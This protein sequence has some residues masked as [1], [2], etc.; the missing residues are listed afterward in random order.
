MILPPSFVG[1]K[2]FNTRNFLKDSRVHLRTDSV[3]WDKTIL[4]D[5]RETH[6][7]LIPNTFRYPKP[8]ETQKGSSTKWFGTVRQNNFDGESWKPPPLLSLTIFDNRNFLKHRRAP[9]RNDSVLRD[10]N[11][12]GKSWNPPPLLSLTIFDTRNLLKHRRV[13][14]RNDSVLRRKILRENRETHLLSYP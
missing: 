10:I 12:E 2:N 14:L 9:L 13:P 5:N 11:F 1:I 8:F 6:S 4:T 3:L 7:S